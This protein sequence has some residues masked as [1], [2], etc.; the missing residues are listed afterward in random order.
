MGNIGKDICVLGSTGSIGTQTLEVA[1]TLGI[2]VVALSANRNVV[3]LW[4]Q[5]KKYR[6]LYVAVPDESAAETLR[7]ELREG[8]DVTCEILTG[9]HCLSD[10]VK[11][12]EIYTVVNA[13]VGG[14][15]VIP[16]LAAINAGKHLAL[17]NKETLVC[18]GEL[19]N[20]ALAKNS[21][22][23]YPIDSEHSAIFQS[24]AGGGDIECIYLTASGGAFRGKSAE[25][26]KT[27]ALSDALV[28][29]NWVMGKKITI[30]SA[31]LMNKGLEVIEACVLFGV[32]PEQIRVV[33]HPQSVV[34]SMVQFRDGS[35]I[36]QLAPPDMRLPIAYALTYPRRGNL[37]F[38]RLDI[39]G[40]DLTFERPDTDT[41]PC[42][43]YAY[44]ALKQ[45]GTAPCILNYANER[46]VSEFLR[47]EIEF[48]QIPTRIKNICDAQ[49]VI[50]DYTLADIRKIEQDISSF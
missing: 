41:F 32:S 13:L 29:P 43:S 31:T 36:A 12:P 8:D 25:E 17:A 44:D 35:I 18:A 20:K 16:T 47:E 15:G 27:V 23:M 9:T 6:P 1:D 10:I 33:V 4:E 38:P 49:N 48:Y 22:K 37:D 40:R 7:L 39:F 28:H 50:K 19:V 46:A 30:D 45:G 14:V 26:L 5:I 42:L 2:R 21:V 34:H 11:K 3:L 24:L